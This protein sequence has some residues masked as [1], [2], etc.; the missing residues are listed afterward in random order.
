MNIADTRTRLA[1]QSDM[2]HRAA[3]EL[4][5]LYTDHCHEWDSDTR[6]D[7]QQLLVDITIEVKP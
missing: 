3:D 4:S 6:A 7:V 2:L 5:A 1:R